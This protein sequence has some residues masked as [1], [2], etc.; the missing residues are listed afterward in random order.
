[1]IHRRSHRPPGKV[2]E[3][4]MNNSDKIWIGFG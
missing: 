4:L 1:M 2:A 3:N